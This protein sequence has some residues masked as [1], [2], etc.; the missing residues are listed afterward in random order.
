M[1]TCRL[2]PFGCGVAEC[3]GS[4]TFRDPLAG[5]EFKTQLPGNSNQGHEFKGSDCSAA[6]KTAG[7]LGCELPVADRWAIIEYL[8]TCDLNRLVLPKAE[9]CHDLDER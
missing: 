3:N 2:G 4:P 6:A 5:F 1:V 7:T 8:K 9:A